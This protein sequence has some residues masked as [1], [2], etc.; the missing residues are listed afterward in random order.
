MS[1]VT[2]AYESG[3]IRHY[4]RFQR[5]LLTPH[6]RRLILFGLPLLICV[7]ALVI[8]LSYSDNFKILQTRAAAHFNQFISHPDLQVSGLRIVAS[9]EKLH[10]DLASLV[11]TKLPVNSLSLDLDD[12]R[13]KAEAIPAVKEAT[14]SIDTGGFLTIAAIERQASVIFRDGQN[15]FLIDETGL[16]LSPATSR[17]AHIAL[18]L[19]SGQ[20]ADKFVPEAL[21]IFAAASAVRDSIRGLVRVG[22][23]R[24]DLIL[25]GDR[26]VLLPAKRPV[27]AVQRLMI[28]E[29]VELLLQRKLISVD[30]RDRR[31]TVVRLPQT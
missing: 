15:L 19:V 23:R 11:E 7:S 6:W 5:I 8:S 1:T 24:W 27:E 22:T 25:D 14:V 3:W 18:P 16:I 26:R 21:E 28:L 4:I 20:D 17:A 30:L 9:N 13:Q 31:R 29:N 10:A 12:L 2:K